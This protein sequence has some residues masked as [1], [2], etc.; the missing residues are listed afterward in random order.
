MRPIADELYH[1]VVPNLITI[2]RF[3]KGEARHILDVEFAIDVKLTL[4]NGMVITLQEKFREHNSKRERQFRDVTVEYYNDPNIEAKG[5]W[6]NLSCQ[7]YFEGYADKYEKG[8]AS[9]IFLDWLRVIIETQK[10]NIVWGHSRNTNGRAKADFKYTPINQEWP[11]GCVL[12]RKL[13]KFCIEG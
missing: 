5:D 8:F 6:F 12:T 2:E 7:M 3:E 4:A 1:R 10:G 9:Y 13:D 11:A